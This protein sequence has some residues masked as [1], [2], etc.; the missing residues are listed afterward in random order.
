[1]I[2]EYAFLKYTYFITKKKKKKYCFDV[3]FY[4]T[5]IDEFLAIFL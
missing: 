3:M 1:M 5:S 4:V 2:K